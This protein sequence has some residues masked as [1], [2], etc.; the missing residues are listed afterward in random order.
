MKKDF[1]NQRIKNMHMVSSLTCSNYL[2]GKTEI[3]TL[4]Y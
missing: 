4:K 1:E 3:N 2:I